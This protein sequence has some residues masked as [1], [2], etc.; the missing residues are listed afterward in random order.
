ME[1]GALV[2]FDPVDL[3]TRRRHHAPVT[4]EFDAPLWVWDARQAD[5]WTF[6]SL[7]AEI[8]DEVD[9]LTAPLARGFGSVRVEVTV[10]ATVWR[11]SIFPSKPQQTYVLPIKKAVRRAERLE[12]GDTARVRIELLDVGRR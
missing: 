4:Y 12:A 11:T 10:G 8:A 7:P 3:A 9:E 1:W 6:V 2:S 5:T